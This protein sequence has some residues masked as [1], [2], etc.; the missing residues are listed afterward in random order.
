MM[1]SLSANSGLLDELFSQDSHH[2]RL[3]K[4]A[5][6][7]QWPVLYIYD[8]V[9]TPLYKA[10]YRAGIYESA[11]QTPALYHGVNTML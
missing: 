4:Q 1:L 6:C 5:R 3:K 7:Y 8:G 11:P 2:Y 10:Q 9:F